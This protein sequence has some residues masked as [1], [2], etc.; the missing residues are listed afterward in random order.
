MS[1][2]SEAPD[3]ADRETVRAFV[4]TVVAQAKAALNGKE[5]PGFLQMSRVHPTSEDLVPTRYTLDDIERIVADA[6]ADSNAG[7]NVYLEA[8]IVSVNLRGKVRGKVEDTVAVF[9]LVIDSDA[10]K[11]RGWAPTVQPSM[12]VETSPGNFQYWFFFRKAVSAKLGQQLGE[13]IRKVVCC[14][15]DTGNVAQ[16]YRV[17]GTVN[18]PNKKKA[19]RGRVIVPTRIVEFDPEELWTPKRLLRAFQSPAAK[20]PT[21]VAA[22]GRG[23]AQPDEASIPTDTM[24][25]IREGSS[26]S[27]SNRHRGQ[28]FW[29]VMTVLKPLGFTVDSIVNLLERYPDGIAVKYEGRLR[30][31]VEHVYQ[32][33]KV[34]PRPTPSDNTAPVFDPWAHYIVPEF[35]LQVLPA[36]L[37]KY[38]TSQSVVIGCDPAALAMSALTV[39]SGAIDHRCAVKMMRNGNWWEHPQIWSLLVGPVSYSKSPPINDA[40]NPLEKYQ[41]FVRQQYQAKLEVYEADIKAN[42]K[43]EKPDKPPRHVVW[44]TTTEKLG[45]ILAR[46]DR[47]LLVKSDELAGWIGSMDRYGGGTR[48]ANADRAFWLKAYDGGPHSHDRVSRGEIYIGNLSTSILGGIQPAKLNEM[49]GL[50]SDGLLQRFVP[51]MMRE[52]T[53]ACD[54]ESNYDGYHELIYKLI[55]AQA[56][57]FLLDDD[58]LR[59]M[60]DLRAYLFELGRA[61]GGLAEGFQSFVGKRSTVTACCIRCSG[62]I[63]RRRLT[64]IYSSCRSRSSGSTA[65]APRCSARLPEMT[66]TYS[67]CCGFTDS[68]AE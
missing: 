16:P 40:T 24:R 15:D 63:T 66:R 62:N 55:K 23:G 49:E 56:Q 1:E 39:V 20:V 60:N 46:S 43:A 48:A 61:S 34:G 26:A 64:C 65:S 25:V 38:V 47:G 13:R 8:R 12:V 9:A 17:A 4:T 32:K 68:R 31:Q 14:D 2:Q 5:I 51:T 50:T 28:I 33:I 54:R 44:N 57:R 27:A 67:T 58:A 52:P 59:A 21:G 41:D 53:L 36:A 22:D 3:Q 35:P 19:E 7:H 45:E 6:V 18:Y 10:D 37:R 29:N 42:P 11:G 30:R